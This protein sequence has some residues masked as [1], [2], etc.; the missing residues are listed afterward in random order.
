MDSTTIYCPN[1]QLDLSGFIRVELKVFATGS[2][3][4]ILVWHQIGLNFLPVVMLIILAY[5][6]LHWL[7]TRELK[8]SGLTVSCMCLACYLMLYVAT[9]S[10]Q[11]CHFIIVHSFIFLFFLQSEFFSES[12]S[13]YLLKRF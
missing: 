7:F 10:Q 4:A 13:L 3:G 8:H 12:W 9:S 11:L 1:Q 5:P 2:I 6:V